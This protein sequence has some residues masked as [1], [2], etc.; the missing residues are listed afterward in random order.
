[1]SG[2][3]PLRQARRVDA[4]AAAREGAPTLGDAVEGALAGGRRLRRGARDL[5]SKVMGESVYIPRLTAGEDARR[6]GLLARLDRHR[7]RRGAGFAATLAFFLIVSGVGLVEGGGY[8][9]FVARNGA[10]ADLAAR[11]AG[12]GIGQVSVTGNVELTDQEVVDLSGVLRTQSLAFLDASALKARLLAEPLIAEAEVRKLFP[13]RLSITVRERTPYA[14]WQKD[15]VI[16]LVSKD[17][18]VIDA[19]RDDR[20]LRLPHVVGEGAN[21]RAGE[22]I[23]LLEAAGALRPRVRAGVLVSGRR[24]TLKLDNGVDVKL[25]EAGAAAALTRLAALER[26]AQVLEKAILSVDL[27]LPGRAAFR[28]TEE[29]A[30]ARAE[31][32]E[33]KFGKKKK[34]RG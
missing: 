34:G 30:A 26:E 14:L 31:A 19:L 9:A 15:G 22:Y 10:P 20:F 25:P 24:W 8:A 1:L 13:D 7:P 11:A 4:E 29:A 12:F 27:R 32:L 28:L 6:D 5:K 2:L 21:A 18:A 16:H 3:P 17:G 23:A 33:E